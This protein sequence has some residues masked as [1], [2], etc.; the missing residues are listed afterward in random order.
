MTGDGGLEAVG[1]S[2]HLFGF[3]DDVAGPDPVALEVSVEAGIEAS[4]S[5]P[6][7][8]DHAFIHDH[9]AP[10]GRREASRER[11]PL[12]NGQEHHGLGWGLPPS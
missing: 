10:P 6:V 9:A 1:P 7:S 11:V 2:A 12:G 3:V 8:G 4:G 5:Q